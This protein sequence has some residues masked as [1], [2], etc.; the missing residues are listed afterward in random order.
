MARKML[1]SGMAELIPESELPRDRHGRIL[2]GGLFSV[3]KN[4]TEDRLIYD[5]RPEN[6][7]MRLLHE[8]AVGPQ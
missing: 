1:Q 2:L 6:E 4:E 3:P 7:T 5:R 8:D